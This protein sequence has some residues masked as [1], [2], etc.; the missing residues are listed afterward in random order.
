MTG[1]L[2]KLRDGS[3][4]LRAGSNITLVTGS[5]GQVTIASTASG[6]GGSDG[7]IG[8]AE[9]G[10]YTDGLFTDFVTTTP[11][12]TAVDRFNEILKI[13]APSP[14]PDV[15]RINASTG[16][17]VSSKLS[18][19]SSNTVSGY[20]NVSSTGSFAA[21]DVSGTYE[22]G[23][24][25]DDFRRGT[26]NGATNIEGI[27]NFHVTADTYDNAVNNFPVDSFGNAEVGF[28]EL[29]HN[30][31]LLHSINLTSSAI[32]SG[33]PGSGAGTHV[34]S[35]GS[36]FIN[37]SVT[38]SA[39]DRSQ[40]QFSIF[41]HRT[42]KYRVHTSDQVNGWN[43]IHVR[44]S[45]SWGYKTTNFVQWV[46]DNNANALSAANARFGNE[47]GSGSKYLSGVQYFTGGTAKYFV[48]VSNAYRNVYTSQN[49]S[50]TTTDCSISS[51][52]FP[53][54][55][56]DAGEDETKVLQITGS[57]TIT[58]SV[59]LSGSIQASVNVA[60]PLKSDLSNGGSASS[61]GLLIYDVAGNSTTLRERFNEE[62]YRLVSGAYDSQADVDS[63]TWNSQTHMTGSGTHSN[64]LQ[65]YNAAL[66]S[67]LNTIQSGDFR[68]DSEGGPFGLAPSGN[69]NYSGE[70]GVRTFYRY[71]RNATGGTKRDISLTTNGS[72]TTIVSAGTA[73]NSGRVKVFVKIPGLTGWMDAAEDFVYDETSD[74]SGAYVLS[75]DSS[76]DALNYLSFGTKGVSNGDD[77][78]MRIEAD[79]SWTGHLDDIVVAFG[80]GIGTAPSE[81]PQLDDIDINDAG[82]DVKLSFGSSKSITGYA[83]VSTN[84]GNSAVDVNGNFLDSGDIAGAFDGT[85]VIDGELNEDVTAN[86]SSYV[87]NSF[88]NAATGSLKLEVNGALVHTIDLSSA[89]VGVGNPGSG[90]DTEVNANGSGFTSLSVHKPG[91]YATNSIP[92][93][94]KIYRTGRYQVGTADQQNGWNYARVIHSGSG[95]GEVTTNY[96]EW[97]NDDNSDALSASDITL[98]NFSGST[99]YSLSGVRYFVA[100]S[101]SYKYAAS[102]VY[103]NVYYRPSDGI[104]FP[105]T[106]NTTV[107]KITTNGSGLASPGTT[108][109][110]TKALPSLATTA[111]SQAQALQVTGT[112]AFDPTE[113]LVGPHAT[114]SH[115][116]SVSSRV[117]HPLK[118]NLTTSTLSKSSFLV[119][120][121]SQ[122]SDLNSTEHFD[123]EV[124]RIQSGSYTSQASVTNAGNAWDSSIS[125]NDVGSH[126]P[127]SNGMLIY[128]DK[129]MS[130][131]TGGL[132]GDFR[133]VNDGGS[134]QAPSS[135]PNYSTLTTSTRE[136]YR[137]FR[138]NQVGDVSL[139]TINLRG[140]ANLI[141]KGGAFNTGSLGAS[142]NFHLEV[143][144][145]GD[146]GWL[147]MARPASLS[148]NIA[149]DGSGGFNGGGADVNQTVSNSG[150]SYGINFR[151]ATLEGTSGGNAD[152]LVVRITAHKDWAGYLS[153][154]SFTYGS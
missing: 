84:T 148:E 120:S 112:I 66:Y 2:T 138:S 144:I 44:H 28:L 18:F 132:S 110:T 99:F 139:A 128:N 29:Y 19:G 62:T 53:D 81:A 26:Y 80:A 31:S 77:I 1:S 13:L 109:G 70:S 67:P 75:F 122:N 140:D 149:A 39:E 49:I 60:H 65:F 143:K 102:N 76:V 86:G 25:G 15:S 89:S 3:A 92:D 12:G 124:Y 32:G 146:T 96:V 54:L 127:F 135:N 111:D 129:L 6:S 98:T 95:I 22:S 147:D 59:S 16:A 14:A 64:G 106:T 30:G 133:N 41:K 33:N 36:G 114:T 17:G 40:N 50:F 88:N 73:L 55:N 82:Q 46:N 137:Y 91:L 145:P 85:V 35:N 79:T 141:S 123:G 45:G 108:N 52:A 34:N 152:Y 104:S 56:V 63:G 131:L 101:A 68:D 117:K 78:V 119:F 7:N 126:A 10:T 151:T 9:D 121:G 20:T 94:T 51:Q 5:S 27:V 23:T 47:A 58:D 116:A 57:A 115:T 93:W 136:Y 69:P 74:G 134:L 105:T 107:S 72:S 42:A 83:N 103:K 118:T 37:V 97:V 8:T 150:T 43:Y 154:I 21:V 125:I 87:A 153:R 130:P 4:Y 71:F 48:E 142:K 113:S 11:V 61:T 90:T 24:S 100:C 38:A